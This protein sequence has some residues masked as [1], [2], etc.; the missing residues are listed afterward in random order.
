MGLV[1]S[2]VGVFG[3][4]FQ[5]THVLVEYME[6]LFSITHS[7]SDYVNGCLI[8][9]SLVITNGGSDPDELPFLMKFK[10]LHLTESLKEARASLKGISGIYCILNNS[11]GQ[12]YLGSSPEGGPPAA[13]VAQLTYIIEY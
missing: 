13:R 8:L 6:E 11:T 9:S 12:I 3:S 2:G 7:L 5:V 10:D 4:L 1:G